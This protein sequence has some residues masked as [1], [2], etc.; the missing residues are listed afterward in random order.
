M[1]ENTVSKSRE[2]NAD[3]RGGSESLFRAVR[4]DHDASA[5]DFARVQ[6]EL[7]RRIV[8][9]APPTVS[10]DSLPSSIAKPAAVLTP[11]MVAKLSIALT[12]LAAGGF[13][14]V[15]MR[16]A[17]PPPAAGPASALMPVEKRAPMPAAPPAGPPSTPADQPPPPAA[18]VEAARP[19]QRESGSRTRLRASHGAAASTESRITRSAS[20]AAKEAIA[21]TAAK[22]A[23]SDPTPSQQASAPIAPPL[24]T[25]AHSPPATSEGR[26]SLPQ[27]ASATAFETTPA[28]RTTVGSKPMPLRFDDST[29]A[30]AELD[31]VERMH[32]ALRA[33]QPGSALEL[34]AEHAKR[35]PHGSL[36]EEREAVSA[37]A[38]CGLR[39]ADAASRARIFLS[40]HPHAPT[41]PRVAAACAP[42]S[43]ATKPV[44]SQSH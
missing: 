30:R 20:S 10:I 33:G 6:A 13:A 35:W 26:A 2:D 34:S 37:I 3:I 11:G 15:R 23:A 21:P 42:L 5:A 43:A 22:V 25:A 8:M 31:L 39:Q 16:G 12:L 36:S 38:S 27:P 7:A 44:S 28:P 1:R 24:A 40:K 17:P 41:A 29:D 18:R 32:A 4:A 14:V 19:G 9:G